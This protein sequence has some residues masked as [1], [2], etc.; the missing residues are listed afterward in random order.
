MVKLMNPVVSYHTVPRTLLSGENLFEQK[1]E[2]LCVQNES[3]N[4]FVCMCMCMCRSV[5]AWR[6]KFVCLFFRPNN[7]FGYLFRKMRLGHWCVTVIAHIAFFSSSF[8]WSSSYIIIF[9]LIFFY[10]SIFFPALL[11]EI[12]PTAASSALD[13]ALSIYPF[14]RPSINVLLLFFS[15]Q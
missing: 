9:V 10:C 2:C 4:H 8:C 15:F 3:D 7:I 1:Y 14:I 6:W 11:F 5:Y 13:S 12:P